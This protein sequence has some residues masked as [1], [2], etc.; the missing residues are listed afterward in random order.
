MGPAIVLAL[1]CAV[2][3]VNVA[4]FHGWLFALRPRDRSNLWAAVLAVGIAT[5]SVLNAFLF[6]SQDVAR[7]D[8][9]QRTMVA[10]TIPVVIGFSRFS[11]SY[12][13]LPRS[14]KEQTV[15]VMALA[16]ALICMIPGVMFTGAPVVHRVDL[17]ALDYVE[18]ALSPVG[19]VGLLFFFG[20]CLYLARLYHR[21]MAP[22]D[23][24]RIAIYTSLA[25]WAGTVVNDGLLGLHLYDG[26][27]LMSVGY[28]AFLIGISSIQIRR[29][30]W[31]MQAVES[32]TQQLREMVDQRTEEL[33]R[34]EV[35]LAYGEQ[36]ATIGALGA[37]LAHEINNPIAYVH[38]NLNQLDECWGRPEDEDDVRDMLAECEEGIER[39]RT[40]VSSLLSI[41]RQS[42]GVDEPV[43]LCRL[44]D[45]ALPIVRREA[46][47]RAVLETSL[48]SVPEV[49]GD[50]RLLGHV[51][52]SLLVRSL[53]AIP[54]GTSEPHHVLVSTA[55]NDDGDRVVLTIRETGGPATADR[56]SGS[57]NAPGSATASA[58][59]DIGLTV[60][61]QL[62]ERF[63]GEIQID[64]SEEGNEIRID[65]PA[66]ATRGSAS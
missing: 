65:L 8:W 38:A 47:Y 33:R 44:V 43:D 52:F 26:P 25:L 34:A 10:G 61:R 64:S 37:S 53:R 7:S 1:S 15:E 23:P 31:S 21:H 58:E 4:V 20:F 30:V 19:Q 22:D 28:T 18:S 60:A 32:S 14:S 35:Q 5:L 50:P 11:L 57:G 56:R 6:H 24:N 46:A 36:M 62:I 13:G 40:I 51:I 16:G 42:D 54:E 45:S 12:L 59:D 3:A 41:A 63:R 49:S 9:I 29:M 2:V 66:A 55:V 48:V 17:L 27:V 39:V